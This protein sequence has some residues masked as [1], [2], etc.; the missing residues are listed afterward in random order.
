MP[1]DTSIPQHCPGF[2]QFRHLSSFTCKCPACGKEIE[3]FSDEFDCPHVCSQC[4]K[5]IDFNQCSIEGS[6]DDT[7]AR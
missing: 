7:S 5:P 3:I 2:E 4:K 6:A 1:Q